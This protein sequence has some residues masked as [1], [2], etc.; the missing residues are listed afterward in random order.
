MAYIKTGLLEEAIVE[1]KIASDLLGGNGEPL[2]AL[3]FVYATSGKRIQAEQVLE[4]LKRARTPEVREA[5]GVMSQHRKISRFT[6]HA[7]LGLTTM[8]IIAL[9][10]TWPEAM[11]A[12]VTTA[13]VLMGP[14]ESLSLPWR[15]A[16]GRE[17]AGE[18]G[19]G[20]PDSVVSGGD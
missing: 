1:L 20:E 13:Y 9:A 11:L 6:V 2:P 12:L 14:V 3:G 5:G 15:R 19:E 7:L 8:A 10:L 4:K 17:P 16:R 18:A